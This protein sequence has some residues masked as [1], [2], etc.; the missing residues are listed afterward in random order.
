MDI[1]VIEIKLREALKEYVDTVQKELREEQGGR[2][3][4]FPKVK[5]KISELLILLKNKNPALFE[6]INGNELDVH[7]F[8]QIIK[9][10][11]FIGGRKRNHR[12]FKIVTIL[13]SK[14]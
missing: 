3:K 4:R 6:P 13:R 12:H 14:L 1:H 9:G 5:L 11:D 7:I 10:F 8:R 2:F